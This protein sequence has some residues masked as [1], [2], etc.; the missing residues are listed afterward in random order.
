MKRWRGD[1]GIKERGRMRE[2][3][4]QSVYV[5]ASPSTCRQEWVFFAS[6]QSCGTDVGGDGKSQSSTFRKEEHRDE[7]P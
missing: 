5:N 1:E 3:R 6:I 2:L 7:K 4:A